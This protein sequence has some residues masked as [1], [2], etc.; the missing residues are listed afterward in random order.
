[1]WGLQSTEESPQGML[2]LSV[3]PKKLCFKISLSLSLFLSLLCL[4]M[5]CVHVHVCQY[6]CTCQTACVEV[7][8]GLR[9][10]SSLS[11]WSQCPGQAFTAMYTRLANLWASQDSPIPTCISVGTMRLQPYL[12]V[13]GIQIQIF[14]PALSTTLSPQ[15]VLFI[16]LWLV[17]GPQACY[18][19]EAAPSVWLLHF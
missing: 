14:T 17:P 13:L 5:M 16:L 11:T 19:H 12:G 3:L 6:Q 9:S 4:C 1:M 7:R 8:D 2:Q 15:K 10:K 18:C